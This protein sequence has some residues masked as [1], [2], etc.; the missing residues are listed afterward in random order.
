M[1]SKNE[2]R[3]INRRILLTTALTLS[4]AS[5]PAYSAMTPEANMFRRI[6]E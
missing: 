3:E 1:L 5:I 2:G 4:L 6:S